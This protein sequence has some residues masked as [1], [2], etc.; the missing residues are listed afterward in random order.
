MAGILAPM[1]RVWF[2]RAFSSVYAAIASIRAHDRDGRYHL[3]YSHVGPAPAGQIAHQFALEPTGLHGDAYVD[4]CLAFCRAQQ[5]DI[6]IPGKEARLLAGASAQFA[7]QGTRLLSAAS[8][9][10]LQL[11]HDK[12]RFYASVACPVAPPPEAQAVHTLAE[13]DAAYAQ[14]RARHAQLCIKPAQSI[15]GLGFAVIDEARSGAELLIAGVQ[16]HIGLADLRAGLAQLPAFRTML[17]MAYLEGREYSADCV[18]DHGRLVAAVVRR[19][20]RSGATQRI[21]QH[22]D[23]LDACAALARAYRLNGCFNVQFRETAGRPRLLEI[24]PRMSGG[25]AMA[26]AAGPNLP[27]LALAGF[28]AGYAGLEIAAV[29]DGACVTQVS[30]ALELA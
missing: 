27:Y 10:T 17:V 20:P 5:I 9:E 16:Y 22:P 23:I 30:Q 14:L 24:N 29:R 26:C 2:N 7:V 12:A 28:D 8:A 25:I 3:V 13:F 1:R 21:V 4:W 18:G 19:K 15:Y 6:F 11:L